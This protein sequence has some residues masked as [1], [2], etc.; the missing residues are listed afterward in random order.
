MA[1]KTQSIHLV[2]GG[3]KDEGVPFSLAEVLTRSGKA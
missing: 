1:D 2:S 3:V